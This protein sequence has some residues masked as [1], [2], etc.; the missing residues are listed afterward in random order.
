MRKGSRKGKIKQYSNLKSNSSSSSS[1]SPLSTSIQ[2]Q[3]MIQEEM[4]SSKMS[5]DE[6]YAR[7]IARLGS[8]YKNN[9]FNQNSTHGAT[10]G[11][12]EDDNYGETQNGNDGTSAISLFQFKN[13]QLTEKEQYEREKSRQIAHYKKVNDI[14]SKC[15]WWMESSSF[16]KY[17]LLSLG[18]H[19]ALVKVPAHLALV[20]GHC[21][22]VPI[23][24]SIYLTFVFYI[25][26]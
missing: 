16:P 17:L 10:A 26:Y 7:N 22:L 4:K 25:R 23:K 3:Q 6:I 14:T 20:P 13:K 5:M 19:V 11:A 21:Y 1:L 9:D 2:I 15:W 8:K 18:N 24:V 12:D